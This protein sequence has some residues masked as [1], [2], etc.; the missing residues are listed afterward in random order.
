MHRKTSLCVLFTLLALG[1]QSV[2]RAGVLYIDDNDKIYKLGSGGVLNTFSNQSEPYVNG[3]A[4]TAA[5][6]LYVASQTQDTVYK[7][8]SG[9]SPSVFASVSSPVGLAIDSSGNVYVGSGDTIMKYTPGGSSSTFGTIPLDSVGGLA[10]DSGGNLYAGTWNTGT[11]YKVTP[12]GSQTTFTTGVGAGIFGLAFDN[13]DNL[14]ATNYNRQIVKI[15]P[16]GSQSVFGTLDPGQLPVSAAYDTQTNKLY[17][18]EVADGASNFG[19]QFVYSY[20]SNG[21]QSIAASALYMP[22][23]LAVSYAVPEPATFA[24]AGIGL[25]VLAI[26]RRKSAA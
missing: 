23:A 5:G 25:A 1:A 10:F 26:R 13:D 17:I 14:F 7:Y 18:G 4:F 22:E 6:I 2:T 15:T 9:G 21:T 3:M 16:E 24:F 20:T 12:G 19:E 11:I 8:S